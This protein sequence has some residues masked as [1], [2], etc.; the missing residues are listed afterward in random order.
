MD[1]GGIGDGAM[2]GEEGGGWENGRME[3]GRG[4]VMKG[5]QKNTIGN[6]GVEGGQDKGGGGGGVGAGENGGTKWVQGGWKFSECVD[7]WDYGGDH[8]QNRFLW[9]FKDVGSCVVKETEEEGGG[10]EGVEPGRDEI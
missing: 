6:S 8:Y 9:A 4:G 10:G 5:A 1:V 3:G 2:E 7:L